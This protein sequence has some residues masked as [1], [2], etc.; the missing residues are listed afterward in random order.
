MPDS[1]N[2]EQ[3]GDE[4]DE[5]I[6]LLESES[7]TGAVQTMN[8]GHGQPNPRNEQL[9]DTHRDKVWDDIKSSTE[10]FDKYMLT[11]SSGALA[12]SLGF[13]KD[14]VPLK[15]A[16]WIASLETSWILFVLCI[17]TTLGSFQFS[18]KALEK[19]IPAL[20][21]YYL[22]DNKDAFN[23]HQKSWWYKAITWCTVGQVTF[24]TL[25]VIFTMTFVMA[26]IREDRM[27]EDTPAQK[28]VTSDL[29]KAIKPAAMTPLTEGQK[30]AG[31][32][33]VISGNENRGIQSVPMTPT[34]IGGGP[35]PVPMTPAPAQGP[36]QPAPGS[37]PAT[38][39][40]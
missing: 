31:M 9:Y 8:A 10:N 29:G 28:A 5:C 2:G 30:P 16:V 4:M 25:A 22:K 11:F 33:P 23:Q 34:G 6:S 17:L 37:A 15:S 18:V 26:N 40:K 36:A 24:F 14:V 20:N 12:L 38:D 1:E 7:E 3:S 13:I 32:T 21:E 39:K 35:K 19:T 27:N